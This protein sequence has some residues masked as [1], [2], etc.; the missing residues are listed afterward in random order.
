VARQV[1][2]NKRYAGNTAWT[3]SEVAECVAKDVG[4]V[5]ILVSKRSHTRVGVA[6]ARY[7][8]SAAGPAA[9]TR[10]AAAAKGLGW[11]V[12]EPQG[13]G[14]VLRRRRCTRW[15]TA[16]RWSSRC[17]RRRARWAGDEGPEARGWRGA[18]LAG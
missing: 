11:G 3:V 18:C 14:A 7:V 9:Q 8:A 12:V 16:P 10:V 17:W 4:K 5:D 1:A 13:K 6:V 2:T 15:P